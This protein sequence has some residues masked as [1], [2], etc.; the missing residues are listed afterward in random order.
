MILVFNSIITEP[1]K[2]LEYTNDPFF[3]PAI[4]SLFSI[5]MTHLT[6]S[7]ESQPAAPTPEPRCTAH[8]DAVMADLPSYDDSGM[9]LEYDE[10]DEN[11]EYGSDEYE[12]VDEN[13]PE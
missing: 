1:R 9:E 8:T 7:L 11:D 4:L 3:G 2:V 5:L 10:V 13:N 6:S 12:D